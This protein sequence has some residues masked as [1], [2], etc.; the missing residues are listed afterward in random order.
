MGYRNAAC[1][2]RSSASD[3]E[4]LEH[5]AQQL[6]LCVSMGGSV[7]IHEPGCDEPKAIVAAALLAMSPQDISGRHAIRLA[8]QRT[9]AAAADAAASPSRLARLIQDE[10]ALLAAAHAKSLSDI[11]R[12]GGSVTYRVQQ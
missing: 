11:E 12:A 3:A 5:H 7:E 8:R 1:A 2:I 10:V 9:L 4:Q 6:R